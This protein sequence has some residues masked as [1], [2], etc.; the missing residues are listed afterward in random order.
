MTAAI[1]DL[2]ASQLGEWFI[3]SPHGEVLCVRMP[4]W[5]PD[6]DVIDVFVREEGGTFTVIDLGEALGWLRLQSIADRRSPKQERLLRDVCL[7]LGVELLRGQIMLRCNLLAEIPAAVH[8]V[9][10]AVLRI[11][12]AS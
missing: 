1:A 3:S 7:T 8:R 4:F 10:Q 9:A 5:Y 12:A 6:G 2:V 11:S